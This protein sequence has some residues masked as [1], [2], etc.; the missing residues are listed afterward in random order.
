MGENSI[1]SILVDENSGI[2]FK[3]APSRQQYLIKSIMHTV[4]DDGNNN[5]W[6]LDRKV[7]DTLITSKTT[8]GLNPIYI[9]SA[10]LANHNTM[11][12]E[13]GYKTKY[14]S[15]GRTGGT[16][17]EIIFTIIYELIPLTTKEAI[18]Q[19]LLNR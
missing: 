16:A 5:A 15:F 8:Q 1:L 6:I 2:Q 7:E 11:A 4:T 3:K 13:G 18:F 19:W 10:D 14:L 12:I 9:A 17:F